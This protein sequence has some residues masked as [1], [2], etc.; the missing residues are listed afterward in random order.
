MNDSF[1]HLRNKTLHALY[2]KILKPIFF[3]YDPEAV[4]DAMT[5]TGVLLGNFYFSR[6]FTAGLFSYKNSILEQKIFGI[7]FKNPIG[8]SAGF[9]KNAQLTDILPSVGFGFAEVGSITARSYGGNPKPRLYRIPEAQ[10]LRVNYGLKNLGAEVLHRN[11]KNKILAFPIGINIAKTNNPET[12]DVQKGIED[13]FFSY[14]LF[15]DIGDYININISCPNTCEEH[16]IFA[17]PQNLDLLLNKILSIPRVKPVFIKLSPDLPEAQLDQILEVCFAHKIDGF[18]C[19]NLTKVNLLGHVGKG[20]FSG[21]AVEELSSNLIRHV[22]KKILDYRK[23]QALQSLYK[24]IVVGVGGVFSAEDAYKKIRAGASLVEMITGM[25][26]QGPQVISEIN[27]GLVAL[28]QRDGFKNI[29][30]AV[31]IDNN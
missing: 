25:I 21:K 15:Q 9:D 13:Y 6:K 3:L 7:N 23:I 27:Q 28:L 18:V 17:E 22:Y 11:L 12:S 29:S 31:G 30:Q 8:L 26:F 5:K 16:P 4:H 24:P 14:K 20:G 2:G 1:I 10:T 19:T